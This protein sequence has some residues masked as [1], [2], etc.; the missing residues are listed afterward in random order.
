MDGRVR[1]RT[2]RAR[3]ERLQ[4]LQQRLLDATQARW[5]GRR[6]E[7]LVE[8][9]GADGAEG[10]SF[11]EGPDSDGVVRVPGLTTASAG[12]YVQ[13]EVTAAE[14]PELLADPLAEAG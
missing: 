4:E 9:V 5:L 14:G 6:L 3:V 12:D 10:R 7:V 11:R 1:A 8:R 13:V 2:A